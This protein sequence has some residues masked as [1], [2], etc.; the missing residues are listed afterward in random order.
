MS[1]KVSASVL[2]FCALAVN[3]FQEEKLLNQTD[4]QGRKQGHWIKKYTNGKIMYEGFFR[5]DHPAGEFKRY[6]ENEVLKSILVFSSDGTEAEAVLYYPN[7]Y[8]ASEGRYSRQQKNGKWRF[9][10][11]VTEGLLIS[12]EEYKNDKINGWQI[13]YYPDSVIAEKQHYSAGIK[14]GDWIK[15]HPN[16]SMHFKTTYENGRLNGKFEAFF[17]NGTTEVLGQYKNNRKEGTWI[18]YD[19]NGNIKFKTEYISGMPKNRDIDL[20]ETHYID[21]LENLK[22]R[23]EDPE[24]T[25]AKW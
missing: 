19:K 9:F 24:K 15:Y 8:K 2:I 12:E 14:D 10:S 20:Y 4:S 17:E 3:T 18:I 21:S 13:K 11:A 1:L 22:V 6:Y 7:G 25:G 23:I 5:D 16:G